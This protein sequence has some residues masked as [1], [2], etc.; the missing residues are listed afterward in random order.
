MHDHCHGSLPMSRPRNSHFDFQSELWYGSD[1]LQAYVGIVSQRGIELFCPEDPDTIRFLS[2][3]V[4]RAQGRS[5]CFWSVLSGEAVQIIQA[6][7][8]LSH[9]QEA[10][11]LLQ[12]LARDYGFLV[13]YSEEPVSG[14]IALRDQ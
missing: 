9:P 6:T 13:P 2:R 14:H 10:L 7:L 1:M 5:A 12:Q 4:Q 11:D 8:N 3:R